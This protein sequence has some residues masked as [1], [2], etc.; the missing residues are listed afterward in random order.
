MAAPFPVHLPHLYHLEGIFRFPP[1]CTNQRITAPFRIAFSLPILS[2]CY[3]SCLHSSSTLDANPSSPSIAP[4]FRPRPNPLSG[5][6]SNLVYL[7]TYSCRYLAYLIPRALSPVFEHYFLPFVF[8]SSLFSSILF[9]QRAFRGLVF[10]SAEAK[11]LP[12]RDHCSNPLTQV[13]CRVSNNRQPSPPVL[14]CTTAVT[15]PR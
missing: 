1:C 10:R 2:P 13:E 9:Y 15:T 14:S 3:Y 4:L 11:K 12:E 6:T 8:I 7:P 5:G